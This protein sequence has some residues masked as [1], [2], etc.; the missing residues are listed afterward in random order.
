VTP[1][2]AAVSSWS[3]QDLAEVKRDVARHLCAVDGMLARLISLRNVDCDFA[4]VAREMD[5]IECQLELM[6]HDADAM[7]AA[8]S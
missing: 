7:M 8:L 2:A 5:D 1:S 3:A 6:H 4:D